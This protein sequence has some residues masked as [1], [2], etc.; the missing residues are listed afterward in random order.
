MSGASCPNCDS[1]DFDYPFSEFCEECGWSLGMC[2]QCGAALPEDSE[3]PICRITPDPDCL[4]CPFV[5]PEPEYWG[6]LRRLSGSRLRISKPTCGTCLD[7]IIE[8]KFPDYLKTFLDP[9]MYLL[10]ELAYKRG[11]WKKIE[12]KFFEIDEDYLVDA[13]SNCTPGDILKFMQLDVEWDQILEWAQDFRFK[14]AETWISRGFDVNVARLWRHAGV[15]VNDACVLDKQAWEDFGIYWEDRY[16]GDLDNFRDTV[17]A[18]RSAK[19]PL[20]ENNLLT[21]WKLSSEQIMTII[22]SG[23]NIETAAHIQLE[24]LGYDDFECRAV[25][26]SG[27]QYSDLNVL[28]HH[29]DTLDRL[30]AIVN[31]GVQVGGPDQL[32]AWSRSNIDIYEIDKWIRNGCTFEI[33][34]SWVSQ[35]FGCAEAV[36]WM[37]TAKVTDPQIAALRRKAGIQP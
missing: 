17:A 23:F 27:I 22:D 21:F 35:G 2:E 34:N 9:A 4:A 28:L 24:K 10:S 15:G 16:E 20:E 32:L 31:A 7:K 29:P 14:D 30:V 1:P 11:L 8:S 25:I 5:V 13:F 6:L 37:K 26:E 19:L 33:A 3:C 36:V 18:L 12:A